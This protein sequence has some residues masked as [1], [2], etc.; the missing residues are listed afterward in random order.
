MTKAM[1]THLDVVSA[2]ESLFSGRVSHLQV[3]G[4]EGELGIMPGHTPLLTP[5][6]PGMVKMVKQHGDEEVFYIS[7]GFLEVQ[8]GGVTV[9]ADTAIRGA[10]LDKAK[11]EEA[12]RTAQEQISNPNQDIDYALVTAQLAQAIAQLRVIKMLRK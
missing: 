4:Q 5:I 7:G 3:S 8:P 11:A 10:D 12:K 2:E 9:L 1:T 6:K